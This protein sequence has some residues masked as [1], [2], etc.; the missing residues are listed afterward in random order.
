MAVF[1]CTCGMVTSTPGQEARCIRCGAMLRSDKL[2]ELAV[3]AG[4]P[5]AANDAIVD[6]SAAVDATAQPPS[7]PP[8]HKPHSCW[9]TYVSL[10]LI[11]AARSLA[12]R[13]SEG[14]VGL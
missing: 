11:S 14:S 9:S 2:L 8:V 12:S 1:Q 10:V 6:G 7:T 13:G 5:S 3:P 4:E